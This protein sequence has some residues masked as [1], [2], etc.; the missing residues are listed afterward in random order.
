MIKVFLV[1]D[2]EI[3]RESI[4]NNIPWEENGY[5]YAGGA[6]DGEMALPMI[7][8][9]KPDIVI[10]DIRMPFMDGL[11][12]SR[13]LKKEQPDISIV[14]L[15][16]YGEFDYAKE[17]I[18]IGV[19][20]FISKPVTAVQLM[21]SLDKIKAEIIEKRKQKES[22][23]KLQEQTEESIR[24]KRYRFLGEI[25][26][27]KLPISEL[28]DRGK[29]LGISLV[30]SVYNF[31]MIKIFP[32]DTLEGE[33]YKK[34]LSRANE[35]AESAAQD[36]DKITVF[37]RMTEGYVVLFSGQDESELKQLGKK[38]LSVLSEKIKKEAAMD[39]FIGVGK[40]VYRLHQLSVSYETANEAFSRQFS[41]NKNTIVI[42][43]NIEENNNQ[44]IELPSE[45]FRENQF[46]N[47]KEF[48]KEG[49]ISQISPFIESYL[50]GFGEE[51]MN[52]FIFCQYI[53]I[54]MQVN[55]Q[56]FMEQTGLKKE[57]L[58]EKYPE[59]YK[60]S[61]QI[62]SYQMLKV[63]MDRMLRAVLE[64]RNEKLMQK[65]HSV[66]DDAKRFMMKNYTNEEIS[67]NAVASE[68][69]LSSSHFS[70]VFKQETGKSFVEH[71]TQLRMES[72]KK[73]LKGTDMKASQISYEVGYKD[74]HYFSY[75]FKKTQGCTPKQYRMRGVK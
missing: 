47:L 50:H 4:K 54:G 11:E 18:K 7:H 21:E 45:D 57:K 66:I 10:T 72:A 36:C 42:Y 61:T 52:S 28:I 39:Y 12:L 64:I 25:I 75:L 23:Q 71:L 70:T 59:Y 14:I 67:L 6:P 53:I 24:Q 46:G 13:I 73:L 40:P 49:E 35:L 63:H 8:E 58:E 19:T 3:I 20:D 68:V 17:A 56:Y 16:G 44:D 65:H 15:S 60:K 22:I 34:L 33:A 48:L 5:N 55:L 32:R 62:A 1:E 37:Y 51:Q 9:I 31:M 26:R 27:N 38:Y 69:G 74:P 2:E 30:A 41:E 29:E 43:E